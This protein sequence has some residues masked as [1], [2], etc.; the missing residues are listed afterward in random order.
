[1]RRHCLP[2][3]NCHLDDWIVFDAVIDAILIAIAL[4]VLVFIIVRDSLEFRKSKEKLSYLPTVIGIAIGI[5][6]LSSL[7]ILGKRDSSPVKLSCATKIIDFNGVWI[8]FRENG[9]YKLTDGCVLGDKVY[10]GNYTLIDSLIILEKMQNIYGINGDILLI[11]ADGIR[12]GLGNI[13][14]SIYV[15]D[16]AGKIHDTYGDGFRVTVDRR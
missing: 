4:L 2:K 9:T 6:L 1:M 10:R 3:S 14:K 11:K 15:I 12:D 7:Y 8:D 5:G 16:K 13:E